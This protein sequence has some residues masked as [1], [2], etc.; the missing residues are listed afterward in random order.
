MRVTADQN[1]K[2]SVLERSTMKK[3]YSPCCCR[4]RI[5]YCRKKIIYGSCG[6]LVLAV[7]LLR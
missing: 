7:A 3:P 2:C 4:D 6:P 1:Y 5:S